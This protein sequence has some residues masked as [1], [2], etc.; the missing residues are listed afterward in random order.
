MVYYGDEFGKL[1]DKEYYREQ[2][3]LTGKDDTRFLVRGRIDW[4]QLDKDLS[5]PSSLASR[6]YSQ[7]SKM[8]KLRAKHK[9]FGRGNIEWLQ[10]KDSLGNVLNEVLVYK[11]SFEGESFLLIHNLSANEVKLDLDSLN[12]GFSA[13]LINSFKDSHN[14]GIVILKEYGYYW[15]KVEE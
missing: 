8:L 1:N 7:I 3:K 2:I 5:D 10:A 15:L 14:K 9:V 11:R 12:I 6:V 13:C 4:T